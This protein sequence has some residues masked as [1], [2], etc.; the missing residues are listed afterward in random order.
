[1]CISR[2]RS[3]IQYLW[4]INFHYLEISAPMCISIHT[5]ICINKFYISMVSWRNKL[6]DIFVFPRTER[7][8]S[9]WKVACTREK[10]RQASYSLMLLYYYHT[11][12]WVQNLI[13]VY[14]LYIS[15]SRGNFY[16]FLQI[17][18]FIGTK[19]FPGIWAIISC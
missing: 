1:M 13:F 16:S 18:F 3:I 9:S 4:L 14:N 11:I 8:Q 17:C 2:C 12:V 15:D 7:K 19:H 10:H 5:C 6:M